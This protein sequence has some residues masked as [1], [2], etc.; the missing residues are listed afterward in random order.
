[1]QQPASMRHSAVTGA[2][3]HAGDRAA[4][5]NIL[6]WPALM[7]RFSLIAE[8]FAARWRPGYNVQNIRQIQSWRTESFY[9]PQ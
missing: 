4:E 9:G 2:K 8:A 5:A 3:S 1:M 6:S 7:G